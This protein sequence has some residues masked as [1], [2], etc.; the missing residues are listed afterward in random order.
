[1]SPSRRAQ[2][3]PTLVELMVAVAINLVV[4]LVAAHLYLNGRTQQAVERARGHV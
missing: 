1:M 2:Q 4:V 3:G